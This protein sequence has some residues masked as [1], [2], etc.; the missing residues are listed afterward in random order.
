M[1]AFVILALG[2]TLGITLAS[3]GNNTS[4]REVERGEYDPRLNSYF[5]DPRTKICYSVSAYTR[6]DAAMRQAAGL[7]HTAVPCT[8]EVMGLLTPLPR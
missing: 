4:G 8:L 1:R 3:C 7:S 2:A 6:T 5:Q